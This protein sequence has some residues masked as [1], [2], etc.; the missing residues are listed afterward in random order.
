VILYPF[1]KRKQGWIL[2]KGNP[3]GIESVADLARENAN[4]VNRQKGAGT[5]I[6]FDLLL[7]DGCLTPEDITGYDREMF[8]HLAV[9]AE[10]NGDTHGAGLGIYPAAKAM[11]LDFVPVAD[12]EYDL[13]MTRSFYESESGQLLLAMIQSEVFKEQVE[14]I[15]G[16]Q[17]VENAEPKCLGIEV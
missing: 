6:L 14:N 10:V 17:V 8:S 11:D 12:E 4:F 16:Y 5:R 2:P 13:L 7:A 9:A 3:L 15:G 1:L